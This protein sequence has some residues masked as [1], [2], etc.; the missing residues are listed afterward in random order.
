LESHTI[1]VVVVNEFPCGSFLPLH[2]DVEDGVAVSVLTESVFVGGEL[3]VARVGGDT[4]DGTTWESL[5]DDTKEFLRARKQ[6]ECVHLLPNSAVAFDGTN[7]LHEVKLVTG[8]K[9]VVV[10]IEFAT[11]ME[12]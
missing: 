4:L 5:K 10:T 8:G 11:C 9:R 6:M 1:K 2:V 3:M 12:Q 7:F